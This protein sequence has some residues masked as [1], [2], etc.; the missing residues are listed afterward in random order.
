[1]QMTKGYL[2]PALERTTITLPAEMAANLRRLVDE[3]EYASTSEVVR[4]ALRGWLRERNTEQQE[5]AALRAAIR[6]GD[7]SG[8]SVA[9]DQVFTELRRLLAERRKRG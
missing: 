2:M 9:A 3:G 4:E 6:E 1:M 8:E 7:E 5:L